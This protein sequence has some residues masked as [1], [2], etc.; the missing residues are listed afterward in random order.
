MLI[1]FGYVKK[2]PEIRC[3]NE[4]GSP[5]KETKK[6]QTLKLQS[7]EKDKQHNRGN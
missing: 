6:L 2:N 4:G 3:R 7:Y 1:K 5:H